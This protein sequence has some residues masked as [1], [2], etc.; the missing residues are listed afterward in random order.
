MANVSAPFGFMPLASQGGAAPTFASQWYKA[1][2]NASAMYHGDPVKLSSGLLVPWTNGTAANLL[3]GIFV[4]CR[5]LS[6]SQGRIV[7][8]NYWPG[9]DVASTE[10]VDCEVIPI[11]R[12]NNEQF[13]VQVSGVSPVAQANVGYN[14][15]VNMGTGSTVTGISGATV[16]FGD[17]G[18]TNTLPFTVIG[19]YNGVGN[20]SDATTPYNYVIVSSN[21]SAVAGN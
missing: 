1:A 21:S 16:A 5:Y 19:L 4:G 13:L 14:I 12:G 7:F 20:G 15:D 2:Y 11:Y 8:N 6:V 17:L 10:K 18:T 9:S 3:V